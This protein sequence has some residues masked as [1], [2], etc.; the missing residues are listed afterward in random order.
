MCMCMDILLQTLKG[1]VNCDTQ[2][3]VRLG[4]LWCWA[5]KCLETRDKQA[6]RAEQPMVPYSMDSMVSG[7]QVIQTCGGHPMMLSASKST[8][9]HDNHLTVDRYSGSRA[10]L[11]WR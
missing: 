10:G 2:Q 9:G 6:L 3:S 11:M 1:P 8:D 7:G 4:Y 5:C